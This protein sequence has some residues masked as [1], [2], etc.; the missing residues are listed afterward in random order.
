MNKKWV[1]FSSG[2]T[3]YKDIFSILP[4]GELKFDLKNFTYKSSRVNS[5]NQY[6]GKNCSKDMIVEWPDS[7]G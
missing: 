3:F 1:N 4:G 7:T 2:E 5:I 6:I